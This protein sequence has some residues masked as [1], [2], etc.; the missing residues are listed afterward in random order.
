MDTVILYADG[1]SSPHTKKPA[2]YGYIIFDSNETHEFAAETGEVPTDV[3]RSV[4]VAE[5]YSLIKG[6]ERA[7]ALGLMKVLIRM[8]SQ[9][10]VYQVLGKYRVKDSTLQ[11]LH[12]RTH[13]LLAEF[14]VFHIE[15]IRRAGN[16]ADALS[17]VQDGR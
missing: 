5:Y 2:G 16:R 1:S 6:L 15:W 11:L 14:E 10:I 13:S 17:R 4:N 12:A 3:G 9:L 7:K 8:D